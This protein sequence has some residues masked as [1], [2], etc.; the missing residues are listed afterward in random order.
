MKL[1]I[2]NQILLI[3]PTHIKLQK[4]DEQDNFLKGSNKTIKFF[5]YNF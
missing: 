1:D 3:K 5:N 4:M 2:F